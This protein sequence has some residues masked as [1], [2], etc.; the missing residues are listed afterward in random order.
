MMNHSIRRSVLAKLA[1]SESLLQEPDYWLRPQRMQVDIHV[2]QSLRLVVL[3]FM[4]CD[5]PEIPRW[6][7]HRARALSVLMILRHIHGCRARAQGTLVRSVCVLDVQVQSGGVRGS[8][9]LA[10]RNASADHK[11]G[12]A[13]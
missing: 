12:I 8:A 5:V 1:R 10:A 6:V 7:F 11:H 13:Y 9:E 2:I 4:R 3:A